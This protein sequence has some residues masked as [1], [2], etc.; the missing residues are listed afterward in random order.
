MKNANPPLPHETVAARAHR[1][2]EEAGRPEGQDQEFWFRAEQELS[3]AANATR[4]TARIG[5]QFTSS[6]SRAREKRPA[7]A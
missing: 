6:R 5:A 7:A 1:L 3:A 4:R 2:W